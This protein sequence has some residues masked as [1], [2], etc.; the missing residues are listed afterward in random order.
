MN[1]RK[2][3]NKL[4]DYVVEQLK[5]IDIKAERSPTSGAK[6]SPGD[7]RNDKFYIEC[8]K[9]NTLSFNINNNVWKKLC[10]QVPYYSHKI[11]LY[12]TENIEGTKLVSLKCEDFFQLIKPLFLNMEII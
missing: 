4:E 1:K 5:K 11:P 9:R 8:K 12:V 3:G 2:L 6:G 7:I 10:K